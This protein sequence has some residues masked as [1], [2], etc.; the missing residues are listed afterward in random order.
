[1]KKSA[2]CAIL[3]LMN[4]HT[5]VFQSV[6]SGFK[7]LRHGV[8]GRNF[9]IL[10]A[11]GVIVLALSFYLPLSVT[12]RYV[13]GILIAL[14][15]GGELFNS[16]IEELSDVLIKEHHPGIARVKE[17]AA[18]AMFFLVGGAI[19]IGLHIFWPYLR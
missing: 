18:G 15:L 6:G 1:M 19:V 11:A 16:S 3:I 17:L 9:K 2:S 10:L 13:I 12:E 14:V 7:G 4:K 5:N 8:V